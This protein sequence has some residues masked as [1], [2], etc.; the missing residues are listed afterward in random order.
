VSGTSIGGVLSLIAASKANGLMGTV[1][2]GGATWTY[3]GSSPEGE[4][5]LDDLARAARAP[6]FFLQA[7]NDYNPHAS[8]RLIAVMEAA[9]KAHGGKMYPAH[10]VGHQ[11]GHAHFCNHGVHEWGEDVLDF[12]RSVRP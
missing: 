6:V 10:G 4:R 5:V 11:A 8:E 7:A 1:D 2:C 9:G 3:D 12:L